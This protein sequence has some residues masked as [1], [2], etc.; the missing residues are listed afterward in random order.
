MISSS[1]SYDECSVQPPNYS[2]NKT[3]SNTSYPFTLI[4][5]LNTKLFWVLP[6]K[7]IYL[8]ICI[9][10]GDTEKRIMVGIVEHRA[11]KQYGEGKRW[12]GNMMK[13]HKSYWTHTCIHAHI[14]NLLLKSKMQELR[15]TSRSLK[16]VSIKGKRKGNQYTSKGEYSY[17]HG[18]ISMRIS[19]IF[20]VVFQRQ[21]GHML[22]MPV[23]RLHPIPTEVEV[24]KVGPAICFNQNLLAIL[25]QTGYIATDIC[26]EAS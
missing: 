23:L 10:M 14:W 9:Y 22:E 5:G 26:I 19:V 2:G 16:M 24:L 7:C 4:L 21:L 1:L 25:M 12:R 13:T 20:K 15:S 6:L 17:S 3:F 11:W 8:G 18:I